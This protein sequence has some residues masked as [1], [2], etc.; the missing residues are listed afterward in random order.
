MF[1][2]NTS[3]TSLLYPLYYLFQ[4]AN[5]SLRM[6]STSLANG[7]YKPI[8]T[9][10]NDCSFKTQSYYHRLRISEAYFTA[11][12]MK[13]SIK[14]FFSKCDQIR[15]FLRVWSHL[16]KKSLMENFIFCA[17]FRTLSDIHHGTIT[18]KT[19]IKDT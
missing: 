18:S 11:L 8:D 10:D 5:D 9:L 3:D 17:V 12:R 6:F 13:F 1:L 14:D 2:E 16:L 7:T 4:R 19:S 15:S